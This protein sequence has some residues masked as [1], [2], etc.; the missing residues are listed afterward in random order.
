MSGKALAAGSSS[1]TASECAGLYLRAD[2]RSFRHRVAAAFSRWNET[3]DVQKP[4]R[5][6]TGGWRLMSPLPGLGDSMIIILQGRCP[7]L[8]DVVPSGLDGQPR[9]LQY[10][11]EHLRIHDLLANCGQFTY[12]DEERTPPA[13]SF[14]R[15]IQCR[16]KILTSQVLRSL[17]VDSW[18]PLLLPARRR[19]QRQRFFVQETSMRN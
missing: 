9:R 11:S 8:N 6:D 18:E 4:R 15:V 2:L 19:G 7:W 5:G 1:E 10:K 12:G 3:R 14:A 17:D 13:A 16:I